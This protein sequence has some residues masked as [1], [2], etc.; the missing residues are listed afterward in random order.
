VTPVQLERSAVMRA[1]V[2]DALTELQTMR[3]PDHAAAT[4][5]HAV[6]LTEQTLAC[7]WIPLLDRALE[8]DSGHK[9]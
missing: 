3:C 7:W 6:K 4:A 1:R 8:R 2:T 9:R 5:M